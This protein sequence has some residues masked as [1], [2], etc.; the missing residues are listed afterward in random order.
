MVIFVVIVVLTVDFEST[1]S[2][3][4]RALSIADLV[5]YGASFLAVA[6]FGQRRKQWVRLLL[7]GWLLVLGWVLPVIT[8]NVATLV[9][10]AFAIVAAIL[11]LPAVLSRLI[12]LSIALAQGVLSWAVD[13]RVDWSGTS[14]LVVIT[15]FVSSLFLLNR[16]VA[17]LRAARSVL[18]H[19]VVARERVRLARDLHDGLGQTVAAIAL[20][21]G[22]ARRMLEA[23]ADRA[24]AIAELRGIEELSRQ[25][26]GDI[27]ATVLD[28]RSMCLDDELAQ[29]EQT[30]HVAG[31]AAE[32]PVSGDVVRADLSELFAYVLREGVTNVVKHSGAGHCQVRLG[33][34][35]MAIQ[36]DGHGSPVTMDGL[37]D[38]GSGNGL[39]GLDERVRAFGGELITG[40][41]SGGGFLLR[42]VVTAPPMTG[43]GALLPEDAVADS[44]A[45]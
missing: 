14:M 44:V 10:L 34:A 1:G 28:N 6:L 36:D 20:K 33:E 32:V 15:L 11:L 30:L 16:T 4:R 40:R 21:S 2:V 23:G 38:T 26:M 3:T 31:I 9:C 13:G 35:W 41:A 37:T 18:A 24:D 42:A 5:L 7:I 29:A 43:A 8:G 25:A 17:H 27:R 22:A 12:G 19:N 45:G 39:L